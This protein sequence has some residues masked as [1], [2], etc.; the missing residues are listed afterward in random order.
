M[1]TACGRVIPTLPKRFR[2]GRVIGL[3]DNIALMRERSLKFEA[4]NMLYNIIYT[5][6][7]HGSYDPR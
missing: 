3:S 2:L 7:A 1:S 6:L 5:Y 4:N